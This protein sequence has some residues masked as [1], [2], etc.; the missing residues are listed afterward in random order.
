MVR[1]G[2]LL[3]GLYYHGGGQLVSPLLQLRVELLHVMS[4]SSLL[5]ISLDRS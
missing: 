4:L 1:V 3:A 2:L 5:S